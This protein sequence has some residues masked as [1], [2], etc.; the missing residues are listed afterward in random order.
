MA[1]LTLITWREL[2]G[3]E[4]NEKKRSHEVL[5]GAALGIAVFT[6]LM[7]LFPGGSISKLENKFHFLLQ[8]DTQTLQRQIDDLK[9]ELEEMKQKQ[10]EPQS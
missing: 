2:V 1:E 10:S 9:R 3:E 7:V 6:F 8:R 4:N 5:G